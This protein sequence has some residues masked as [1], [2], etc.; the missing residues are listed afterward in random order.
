MKG[1]TSKVILVS[2][3]QAPRIEEGPAG[4]RA[5]LSHGNFCSLTQLQN[6][7]ETKMICNRRQGFEN[8]VGRLSLETKKR[9]IERQ[10]SSQKEEAIH[11][12]AQ[13]RPELK[14]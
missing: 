3:L 13:H 8:S 6:S 4:R 10:A 9:I 7:I 11:L 14:S 5:N 2:P 12:R 1:R